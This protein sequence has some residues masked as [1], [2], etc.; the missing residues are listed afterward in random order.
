MEYLRTNLSNPEEKN[1]YIEYVKELTGEWELCHYPILRKRTI[2]QNK[3]YQAY[4]TLISQATGHSRGFI[5]REVKDLYALV[6]KAN[7]F[8]KKTTSDMSR[9]E[10][11]HFIDLVLIRYYD[12]LGL[13]GDEEYYP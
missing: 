2:P 11:M 3:L 6:V 7:P 13:D 4:L 10:F 1:A 12:F 5:H 8:G 9:E